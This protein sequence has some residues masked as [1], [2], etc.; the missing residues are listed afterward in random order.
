M[1][2]ATKV[3]L[4]KTTSLSEALEQFNYEVVPMALI[5]ADGKDITTHKATVRNDNGLQLGI[6]G[7]DYSI[8][9]MTEVSAM[10][11]TLCETN[12]DARLYRAVMFDGGRRVHL[13]ASIGEFEIE[14]GKLKRDSVRKLISIVNS[15][16]GSSGYSV[17][18]EAER[19]VCS[20][21]MRRAVKESQVSLR[22]S[23]DVTIK[24]H[25]AMRIMG[26]AENHFN[27]FENN[28]K[29][30]VSQIIDKKLVDGLI[31]AVVGDL[32]STRA[33]NVA[34]EIEDLIGHGIET[35]GLNKWDAYN[36]ITQYYDHHAG[37]D[38]EKRLASSLIGN[39]LNKKITAL[40][41]LLTA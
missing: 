22:H 29:Q 24:L 27:V 39:G 15:F 30:L 14:N 41:Y 32:D 38:D 16:D 19:V 1:T 2:I 21:G 5:R 26:I 12:P 11:K 35:N 6:V 7:K 31:N 20:N 36:A 4:S 28:C 17:I 3:D 37:K 10:M 25:Q 18:F 40:N 8:I 23:G 13:T 33:K 34:N 9:Q